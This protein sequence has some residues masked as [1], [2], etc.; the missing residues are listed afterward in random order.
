MSHSPGVSVPTF[1]NGCDFEFR[2]P[3]RHDLEQDQE[4]CELRQQRDW[5]RLRFHDYSD[6]YTIPGLYESLFCRTLRCSSPVRVT[7]LLDE[8]LH[9]HSVDAQSLRVLDVGAGNG[10]VGEQLRN[11]G[12]DQIHGVDIIPEAR[13]AA[14]RDRP[15]VYDDYHV[16]DL[17]DL[18]E[19][20][21]KK[22]RG[23]RLNTLVTVA[24]LGFGDIPPRAFIE[25]LDLID[26]P[27]WIAFNIKEDFVQERDASGFAELLRRL[28][29]DD[30]LQ[31]HAYRRYRHRLAV[32]GEPLHYIAMV[33][34]KQRDLTDDYRE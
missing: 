8:V 23:T 3:D 12:V 15:W 26:V 10:M 34:S 1:S 19:P 18:P 25:A 32:D 29:R 13:D 30:I 4:W 16:V 17:C 24:A 14:R 7:A 5:R 22:L 6:I 33:A 11:L 2:F 28:R 20:I 27:G 31:M 9:E 21:D